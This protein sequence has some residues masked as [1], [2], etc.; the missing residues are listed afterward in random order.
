MSH[1]ALVPAGPARHAA[2]APLRMAWFALR[3]VALGLSRRRRVVAPVQRDPAHTEL[4]LAQA[5]S[6]VL[7]S[8]LATLEPRHERRAFLLTCLILL[9]VAALLAALGLVLAPV[10]PALRLLVLAPVAVFLL[11]C[12][13][14][15]MIASDRLERRYAQL[16][17]IVQAE[18]LHAHLT[19]SGGLSLLDRDTQDALRGALS[20]NVAQ[21][22]QIEEVL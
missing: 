11:L 19:A 22:G 16:A 13:A 10:I 5:R 20:P 2:L 1:H 6:L 3:L 17:Y 18:R 4:L 8:P 14:A 15:T 7:R 21:R 9:A 12:Y